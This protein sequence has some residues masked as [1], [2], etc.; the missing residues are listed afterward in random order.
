MEFEFATLEK[1]IPPEPPFPVL[2]NPRE[3]R[4]SRSNQFAEAAVPGLP[5][6]LLQFGRGNARTLSMQLFFDTY[7]YEDGLDVRFYTDQVLDLLE[8][9]PELHAPPVCLFSWG[10]F[11]F[12]GVLE[13]ANQSFKLFRPDGVPVRA[14]I[15]VTWK[16]FLDQEV[17]GAALQSA[18]FEKRYVVRRGDTLSRIAGEMYDDPGRWREIAEENDM[19]DPLALAPGQVLVIPALAGGTETRS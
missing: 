16:E 5:G 7:T 14:T 18:D 11:V 19:D 9:D 17:I 6:P 10:A 4:L 1:L 13:R 3:Y 15:D 8:I 2:F 12:A